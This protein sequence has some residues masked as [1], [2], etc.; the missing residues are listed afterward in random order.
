MTAWV[1]GISALVRPLVTIMFSG[2]TVWGWVTGH[3]SAEAF[4]GL[5]GMTIGFWFQR[6]D[7]KP[8]EPR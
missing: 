4:L 5:A 2:A 7:E 8:P 3:L 1:E 6:R